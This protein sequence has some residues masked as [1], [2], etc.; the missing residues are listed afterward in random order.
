MNIYQ[1]TIESKQEVLAQMRN[2]L[3]HIINLKFL[4]DCETALKIRI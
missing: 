2:F 1:I 4:V 3:Y